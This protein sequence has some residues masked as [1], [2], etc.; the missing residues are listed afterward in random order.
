M[1]GIYKITNLINGKSYIGQ[2]VNIQKR[3]SAHKSAAFNPNHKNYNFPLYKAIRKYGIENFSF[4]ILEECN[5]S[6]LDDKEIYYIAKYNTHSK[7]G[8]NQ[9]NGGN[10]A[11]HYVKLSD[12]L[13]DLIIQRLKT[14][15][16]NSED[17]GE[18][19]GVTGRTIRGINSGDYCYKDSETYPIRPP[20]YN[21]SEDGTL[22][23]FEYYCIDCGK[24]IATKSRRC[25][26]CAQKAQRKI[27][28]PDPIELARLVKE[29]GFMA[30][31]RM[32]DVDGNSIKQ[33]C[34]SYGLPY[35][36]NKLISW[37]NNQLGIVDK[38]IIV[39]EKNKIDQ[40]NE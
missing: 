1:I 14:S 12:E 11:S 26:E 38:M 39:K 24:K 30:T 3:F 25:V 31:G 8:Y 15:L 21:M 35:L 2:S 9:D 23:E 4:E 5:M 13:V 37:Y 28:R 22:K 27:D 20:L 17:I 18:D 7:F 29:Y 32:F 6:E 19:F 34:K 33:W 40:K 16:D 10:Q 36:K